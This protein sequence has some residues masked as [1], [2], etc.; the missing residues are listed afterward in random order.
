MSGW[1]RDSPSNSC[2]F[3]SCAVATILLSTLLAPTVRIQG[4]PFTKEPGKGPEF[5]AAQL[6][7]IPFCIAANPAIAMLSSKKGGASF[8]PR[9]IDITSTPSSTAASNAV[10][11]VSSGQSFPKHTLYIAR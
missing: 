6:T 3:P 10:N 9:D 7:K 1:K 8:R 2:P 5:P 4:A 11:T